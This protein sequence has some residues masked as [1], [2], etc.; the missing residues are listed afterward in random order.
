M[1]EIRGRLDPETRAA[2][3]AVLAKWAAPG[4]CNPDDESPR[5]DGDPAPEAASGDLRST[6]QRNHD[7][8][9][10]LCRGHAGLWSVGQP[11]RSA[12]D[13]GG[14]H[15]TQRTRVRRGHAVT[16]GGSLLPMSDAIRLGLGAHTTT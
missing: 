12:G 1:S 5:V 3:D 2:L 4:M 7:A 8:L 9:K 6:G 14:V 13:H 10:A 11:Q 15:D 16:G